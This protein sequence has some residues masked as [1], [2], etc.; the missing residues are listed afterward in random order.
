MLGR[1]IGNNVLSR[2][3]T[4]APH[5]CLRSLRRQWLLLTRQHAPLQDGK[6]PLHSAA[7][8][9]EEGAIRVLLEAGAD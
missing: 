6:T 2:N 3:T 1:A 9:G 8:E 5:P 4:K 7:R